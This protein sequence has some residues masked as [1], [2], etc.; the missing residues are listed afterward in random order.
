MCT[1]TSRAM[2]PYSHSLPSIPDDTVTRH[3]RVV[4]SSHRWVGLAPLSSVHDG[5]LTG[6]HAATG[7]SV[8][9]HELCGV[10]RR[11]ERSSTVPGPPPR[12][13]TAH[14][15]GHPAAGRSVR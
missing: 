12:H 4:H 3:L 8:R 14:A 13:G 10:V 11:T 1:P 15:R 5:P 9:G 7:G 6:H 2:A